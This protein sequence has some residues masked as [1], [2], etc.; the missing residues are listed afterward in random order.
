[1][2]PDIRQVLKAINDL[3]GRVDALVCHYTSI[4][5]DYMRMRNTLKHHDERLERLERDHNIEPND[6]L[7]ADSA[8]Y[9]AIKKT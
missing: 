9:P 2:D 1:M 5:A 4:D 3:V 6:K 8:L 7:G